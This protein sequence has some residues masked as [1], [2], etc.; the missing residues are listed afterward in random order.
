MPNE[1]TFTF[2][3]LVVLPC[4]VAGSSDLETAHKPAPM[5]AQIFVRFFEEKTK[6]A[7]G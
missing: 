5:P 1:P 4:R 7:I 3:A 6:I 2:L